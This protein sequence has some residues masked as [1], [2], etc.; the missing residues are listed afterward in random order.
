[1]TSIDL[2]GAGADNGNPKN[3]DC[4]YGG[5]DRFS[6]KHLQGHNYPHG[7]CSRVLLLL[8]YLASTTPSPVKP[9][10]HGPQPITGLKKVQYPRHGRSQWTYMPNWYRYS[11][12]PSRGIH[13][14]TDLFHEGNGSTENFRRVVGLF[15]HGNRG[16]TSKLLQPPVGQSTGSV[17][18]EAVTSVGTSLAGSRASTLPPSVMSAERQDLPPLN[19]RKR[20]AESSTLPRKRRRHSYSTSQIPGRSQPVCRKRTPSLIKI[21]RK[22]V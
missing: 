15:V 7:R 11:R 17:A 19:A 9:I 8:Q 12:S 18:T 13:R 16:L 14:L 6:P 10:N 3:L 4:G 22:M 21:S 20:A 5:H 1:L 2:L